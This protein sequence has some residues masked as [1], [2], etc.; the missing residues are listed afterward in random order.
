MLFGDSL[1]HTPIE[2]ERSDTARTILHRMVRS[3][4]CVI[5]SV[6]VEINAGKL[7]ASSGTKMLV[8]GASNSS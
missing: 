6:F 4:H 7:L 1:E 2:K 5:P 3:L 8:R